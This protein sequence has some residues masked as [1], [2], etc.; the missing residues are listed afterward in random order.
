MKSQLV[1]K[2]ENVKKLKTVEMTQAKKEATIFAR[3]VQESKK[4]NSIRE[5]KG[6]EWKPKKGGAQWQRKTVEEMKRKSG[7]K[8]QEVKK[9]RKKMVSSIFT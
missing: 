5:R 2:M 3:Q 6:D 9:K 7:G 8:D 1:D 4:I